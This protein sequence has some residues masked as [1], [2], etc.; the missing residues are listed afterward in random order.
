MGIKMNDESWGLVPLFG[1]Y[2]FYL[3]QS[4]GGYVCKIALSSACVKEQGYY[5]ELQTQMTH[6]M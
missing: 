6:V 1:I 4:L 5:T 3:C 2:H